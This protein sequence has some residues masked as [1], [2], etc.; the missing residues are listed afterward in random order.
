MAWLCKQ[1]APAACGSRYIADHRGIAWALPRSASAPVRPCPASTHRPVNI[2]QIVLSFLVNAQATHQ[3]QFRNT[4]PRTPPRRAIEVRIQRRRTLGPPSAH[5]ARMTGAG[6][7]LNAAFCMSSPGRLFE[8]QGPCT[9]KIDRP[10]PAAISHMVPMACAQ[11]VQI[12]AASRYRRGCRQTSG[13]RASKLEKANG[14]QRCCRPTRRAVA[15]LIVK[16]L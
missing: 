15:L 16:P 4:P 12:Q 10:G 6:L 9:A 8:P 11:H 13:S 5:W 3:W 2:E 1:D 7:F 14:L